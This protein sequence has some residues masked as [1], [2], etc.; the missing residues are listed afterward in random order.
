MSIATLKGTLVY[1]LIGENLISFTIPIN[2]AG[3][4][5]YRLKTGLLTTAC[6]SLSVYNALCQNQ[7]FSGNYILAVL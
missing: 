4:Y 7:D 1:T 5:A 2:S 6:S 3:S